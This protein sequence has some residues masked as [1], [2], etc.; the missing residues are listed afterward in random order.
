MK[1]GAHV[2]VKDK[3]GETIS[4]VGGGLPLA[5]ALRTPTPSQANQAEQPPIEFLGAG[6]PSPEWIREHMLSRPLTKWEKEWQ[7]VADDPELLR[8]SILVMRAMWF[9]IGGLFSV[10][11]MGILSYLGVK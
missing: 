11:V 5:G 2:T 8:I 4:G 7:V 1:L 3:P 6:A 10:L 9:V